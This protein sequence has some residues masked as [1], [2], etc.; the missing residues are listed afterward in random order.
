MSD[1]GQ[2]RATRLRLRAKNYLLTWPQCNADPG[3]IMRYLQD[4]FAG[5]VKYLCVCSELHK[6]GDPHRHA[7]LAL[8]EQVAANEHTFDIPNQR[9]D[10][11]TWHGNYQGARSPR[12]ALQYVKK[13]GQFIEIGECPVKEQM[14]KADINKMILERNLED[15]V[16]EGEISLY[17]YK[18]LL[19][20]K[21]QYYMS[22]KANKAREKPKVYWLW[23]PTGSGKTRYAV[24]HA[25]EEYWI[26]NNSEWFDGYWGQDTVII[27]DLRASTYKY[28]FLLRLLDRYPMMV[29]I[30]GGWQVWIP[31]VI[32]ITAPEKPEK[33]FVNRE[34]GEAW[35]SIDQLI[36]RVDEFIEFPREEPTTPTENWEETE[37][38]QRCPERMSYIEWH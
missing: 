9:V 8:T 3:Y 26:S 25:G 32:Y 36:R 16:D 38:P 15:L 22:R 18:Q 37:V 34:T 12:E 20:A 21:Q 28:S 2:P 1:N 13:D 7:F 19:T 4:K 14:S 17:R 6:E 24:E 30:K 5:K 31:K 10:G 11:I 29:Q 35:D 27:D 23:G 33:V